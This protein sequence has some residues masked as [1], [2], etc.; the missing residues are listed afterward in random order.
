MDPLGPG[1]APRLLA[2]E[3]SIGG[4]A[5]GALA[6]PGAVS[7]IGKAVQQAFGLCRLGLTSID[8]RP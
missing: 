6:G 5:Q 4:F 8:Y 3:V 7:A 1:R 2:V